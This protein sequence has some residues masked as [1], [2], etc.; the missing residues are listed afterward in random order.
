MTAEDSPTARRLLDAE[1]PDCVVTDLIMPG[2]S[3]FSLIS[4][5]KR[6]KFHEKIPVIVTSVMEAEAE[7]AKLGADAYL[8]KPFQSKELV[9]LV[10]RMAAGTGR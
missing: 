7:A 1:V 9:D 10:T 6:S 2:E 8:T 5:M 4:Y 3:G